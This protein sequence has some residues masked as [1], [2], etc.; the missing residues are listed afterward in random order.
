MN[1]PGYIEP[2]RFLLLLRYVGDGHMARSE[3]WDDYVK[4]AQGGR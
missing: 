2:E 3:K 4:R 1:V